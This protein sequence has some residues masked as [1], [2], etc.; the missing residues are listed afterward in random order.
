M[1]NRGKVWIIPNDEILQE[2]YFDEV[3]NGESHLKVFQDFVD[4]FKIDMKFSM[5]DY[6]QAPIDIASCGHLVIKSDDDSKTLIFYIPKK[7]TERQLEFF[8]NNEMS[9]SNDYSKI[10]GFS[11]EEYDI[12]IKHG[13]IEIRKELILKR[14]NKKKHI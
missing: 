1:F 2:L 7:T 4:R 8:Q 11:L 3:S 13:I 12:K 10:G 14:E 9:F 6:Q 5:D